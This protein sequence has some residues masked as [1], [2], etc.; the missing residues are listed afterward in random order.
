MKTR[1]ALAVIVYLLAVSVPAFGLYSAFGPEVRINLGDAGQLV[2]LAAAA[3]FTFA[4][5]TLGGV[6]LRKSDKPQWVDL[7]EAVSKELD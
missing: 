2:A 4:L 6:L 5:A 1:A 3:L 7:L